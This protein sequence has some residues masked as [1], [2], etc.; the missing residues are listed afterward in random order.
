MA[1]FL[2]PAGDRCAVLPS[3]GQELPRFGDLLVDPF[4]CSIQ[5]YC[6]KDGALYAESINDRSLVP[7]HV[8]ARLED[9]LL[10]YEAPL[11]EYRSFGLQL[12]E[13]VHPRQYLL[14]HFQKAAKCLRFFTIY[15]SIWAILATLA[16]I[17]HAFQKPPLV[18]AVETAA[19]VFTG[20]PFAFLGAGLSLVLAL[21]GVHSAAEYAPQ[22]GYAGVLAFITLGCACRA[23][24]LATRLE[25]L[26]GRWSA[27]PAGPEPAE[28]EELFVPAGDGEDR[29][30]GPTASAALA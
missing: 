5:V 1:A 25:R 24:W 11:R 12:I 2:R 21:K 16:G 4:S 19:F 26:A 17:S 13:A 30:R 3:G 22:V 20:D 28:F 29:T 15:A 14:Y 8:T 9:P 23:A 7:G 6:E 18:I 10:F 27:A